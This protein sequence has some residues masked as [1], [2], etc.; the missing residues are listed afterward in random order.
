MM[1][2]KRYSRL[3][4]V[5]GNQTVPAHEQIFR[6]G[7]PSRRLGGDRVAAHPESHVER[8]EAAQRAALAQGVQHTGPYNPKR[9]NMY[10]RCWVPGLMAEDKPLA[11][12]LQ[13]HYDALVPWRE[14]TKWDTHQRTACPA[15]QARAHDKKIAAIPDPGKVAAQARA[16]RLQ[17]ESH[18]ST[19]FPWREGYTHMLADKATGQA[20]RA[21]WRQAGK[22]VMKGQPKHGR[23]AE[24][25]QEA[26]QGGA[27]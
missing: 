14:R 10:M 22:C 21:P 2:Q 12:P 3:M 11:A 24:V 23:R 8:I 27:Q 13:C 7:D 18:R 26:Q 16:T 15:A 20:V 5:A 4:V 6:P 1:A 19:L 17:A 25:E 9:N